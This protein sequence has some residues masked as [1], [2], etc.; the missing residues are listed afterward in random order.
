M[1]FS[2]LPNTRKVFEIKAAKKGFTDFGRR[3]DFYN[4]TELN[5]MWEGY[6]LAV[7]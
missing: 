3:G 5:S 2:D 1:K 6:K 4:L 7:D